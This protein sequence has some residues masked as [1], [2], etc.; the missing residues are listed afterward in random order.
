MLGAKT[1]SSGLG[2]VRNTLCEALLSRHMEEPPC[3][4]CRRPRRA[5][6][7]L[8]GQAPGEVSVE[9]QAAEPQSCRPPAPLERT[10]MC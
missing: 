4:L 1:E 9:V 6:L 2:A 5:G 10:W 8:Q 3:T 7:A